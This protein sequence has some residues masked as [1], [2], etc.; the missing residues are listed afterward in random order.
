MGCS[1]SGRWVRFAT[2]PAMSGRLWM[3][4]SS[5]EVV[6]DLSRSLLCCLAQT[7]H[8]GRCIRGSS[9]LEGYHAHYRGHFFPCA[10][11]AGPEYFEL[12]K[13]RFDFRWSVRAGRKLRLHSSE[14]NN[15]RHFDLR[16]CR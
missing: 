3:C 11:A 16:V 5:C 13:N 7:N 8:N 1:S 10:F 14:V 4:L 15:S 6:A 12:R 9:A 2:Y